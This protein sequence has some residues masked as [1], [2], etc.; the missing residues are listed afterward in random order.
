MKFYCQDSS[1]RPYG[2]MLLYIVE[3][4]VFVVHYF[5]RHGKDFC[6]GNI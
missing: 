1:Q 4:Q 5:N 6:S 3:Q 2:A